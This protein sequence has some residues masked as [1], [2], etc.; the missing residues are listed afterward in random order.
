[1]SG[2]EE[3]LREIEQ[4][5]T[6]QIGKAE[7]TDRLNEIRVAFLG[8]KGTLTSVMK[9]M[10]DV[11]PEERP[12]VGKWVNDART[13]IESYL[14]NNRSRLEE[15]ALKIRLENEAIDV[16][17]PAK[18]QKTGHRHPNTM[19]WSASSSEWAMKCL[20][21]RRSSTTSTISPS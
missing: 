20:R 11:P 12:Q 8:K 9:S 19:K 7:G 10:K 6:E 4:M 5:A 15:E 17:L 18:K 1:M 3:K 21:V 2:I 13:R 14:E 16:T